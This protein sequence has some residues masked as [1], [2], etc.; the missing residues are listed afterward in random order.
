MTPRL[1]RLGLV[2]A[3]LAGALIGGLDLA[4]PLER[5]LVDAGFR[6]LRGAALPAGIPDI[7]VVGVDERSLAAIA[8]P[9]ALW[10]RQLGTLLKAAAAAGARVVGLDVVLP[11]KSYAALA[12][13]L[14]RALIDGILAMRQAGGV[15][16]AVTADEGGRPRAL[17]APFR[18]A[19]GPAG[20]GYALWRADPDRVVRSF[21]ER[22]GAQG[23]S[24]P[25]FAGQ[26]A[27]A[28]GVEPSAGGIDYALG[29]GFAVLSLD[30]VLEW[31]RAGDSARLRDAFGGKVLL[32]G[33]TL[34][35]VDRFD[36]PLPLSR[37]PGPDDG[38]PG[39]LVQAQTLR[40]LLA[41]R[42]IAP[43]PAWLA[44][45]LAALAGLAW[46]PGRK[47]WT[48]AAVVVAVVVVTFAAALLALAQGVRLPAGAIVVS[49]ALAAGSRLMLEAA[50]AWRE[51]LRL[52]GA[53]SGYVSPQVMGEIESGRL[54]GRSV[55]RHF[56]CVLM[57]D[58]RNF[59]TRSERETP[60]RIVAMLN[61]LC[62]EATTAIHAQGGTVDKFMGDG[63][64]AFFGAPVQMADPCGAAFAAARDILERLRR[65]SENLEA[66][67]E[68]PIAIGIGLSCGDA[69]VGHIG[70]ATR[71]A[72]TA[73]GDCVNV[74]ARL[75]SLSKDL[76]YP[77]LLSRA[78]VDKLVDNLADREGLVPLGVQPI[79]GHT[80]LE[81][82]G[83]R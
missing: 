52:R 58:V 27:R 73:I 29:A 67:G 14:D 61:A 20:V 41:R 59:T 26:L 16:L 36:T 24:V 78:V 10:H 2:A 56:L 3:I 13:D 33:S 9:M 4:A 54:A 49:A 57:L 72:Y 21:D 30:D 75:E 74:A 25:T 70:A 34:P 6:S 53:F 1:L 45:V 79:K 42:G 7:A 12:P 68:S 64:L 48:A 51:R 43:L 11:D 69:T 76:G 22:L 50:F 39:V 66:S 55:A 47:P 65:M 32:V 46:L 40:T 17:Y 28:L 44:A 82:Y 18:A 37:N 15:V 38:E 35:F 31:A 80:S 62:E 8:L 71:H 60:E 23:E 83:W 63:I 81:V 5:K 77:L 19:A